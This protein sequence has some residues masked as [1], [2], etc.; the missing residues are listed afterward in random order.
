MTEMQARLA[1]LQGF[2]IAVKKKIQSLDDDDVN[3]RD[4]AFGMDMNASENAVV[5]ATFASFSSPLTS[6]D[7]V[8]SSTCSKDIPSSE[9]SLSF[10]FSPR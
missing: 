2:D 5:R 6:A 4:V 10:E 3:L 8:S 7:A 1:P 9:K